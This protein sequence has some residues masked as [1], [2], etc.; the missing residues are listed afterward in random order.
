MV[1]YQTLNSVPKKGHS[2]EELAGLRTKNLRTL[3]NCLYF[4][5]ID[6]EGWMIM[7]Q[8]SL[9]QQEAEQGSKLGISGCFLS[10]PCPHDYHDPLYRRQRSYL[11]HPSPPPSSSPPRND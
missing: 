9:L 3:K 7:D 2:K 6:E 11:V 5:A 1:N 8:K 10:D 4:M